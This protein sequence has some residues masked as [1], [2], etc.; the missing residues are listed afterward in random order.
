MLGV[1]FDFDGTLA[2]TMQW[3]YEAWRVALNKL[4]IE[5]NENDYYPLEGMSMHS[6]ARVL[7]HKIFLTDAQINQV[8]TDK[9]NC[10]IASST[11]G[12]YEGVESLIHKLKTKNIPF[13]IV[14]SSHSEQL[15]SK[16]DEAF[17]NQFKAIVTG[18]KVDY[19]K[20]DPQ[21]YLIGAKMLGLNPSQCIAVENAP[22][23]IVSA[24]SAGMYCIAV[25]STVSPSKLSEADLI[26]PKIQDIES[27]TVFIKLHKNYERK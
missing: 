11:V 24:K 20:P 8:V 13:G 2:D 7:S 18:D 1:L 5:V 25:S 15:F 26:V 22:L 9:K 19:G 4:G 21:P 6:I 3:H 10:F 14:T 23:G 17:L 12:L 27:S 16:F